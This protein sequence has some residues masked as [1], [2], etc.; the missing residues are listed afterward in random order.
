[1]ADDHEE[2][3]DMEKSVYRKDDSTRLPTLA[4]ETMAIG[5]ERPREPLEEEDGS[6]RS[7]VADATI[8]GRNGQKPSEPIPENS[9][10]GPLCP[11]EIEEMDDGIEEFW[12]DASKQGCEMAC[13]EVEKGT[14]KRPD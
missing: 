10:L 3:T 13:E 7:R 1:M 5:P 4:P 9:T 6:D 12:H 14:R 8:R 11:H 2:P